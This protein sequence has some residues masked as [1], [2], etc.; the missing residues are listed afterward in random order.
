MGLFDFPG[1]RIHPFALM[2]AGV[3]LVVA[4]IVAV[5]WALGVF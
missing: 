2:G 1:W 4:A 5:L 3:A